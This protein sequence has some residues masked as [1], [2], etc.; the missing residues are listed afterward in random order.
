[1]DTE[2]NIK[3]NFPWGAFLNQPLF[4]PHVKLILNPRKF[5]RVHDVRLLERCLKRQIVS[6][7][8]RKYI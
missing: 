8:H 4:H 2:N 1:M 3:I 5:Q 7:K 6:T